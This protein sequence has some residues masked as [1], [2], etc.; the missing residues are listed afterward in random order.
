[1]EKFILALKEIGG[2]SG[3]I[4]SLSELQTYFLKLTTERRFGGFG[5][6]DPASDFVFVARQ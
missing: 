6:D 4:V 5:K 3:R 2:G 1:M